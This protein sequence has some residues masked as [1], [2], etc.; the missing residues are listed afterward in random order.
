M[1]KTVTVTVTI[2]VWPADKKHLL[3]VSV[4]FI[5]A[6]QGH[7]LISCFLPT[8]R[9]ETALY[10]YFLFRAGCSETVSLAIHF[11][12]QCVLGEA[13]EDC[14]HQPPATTHQQIATCSEAQSFV[15]SRKTSAV[16]QIQIIVYL[17]RTSPQFAPSLSLHV[18]AAIKLSPLSETLILLLRPLLL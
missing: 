15:K 18:A 2:T 4:R 11:P 12:W 6:G 16:L 10:S 9:I 14:R 5:I 7:F 3:G 17:V 1:R 8:E 13:H